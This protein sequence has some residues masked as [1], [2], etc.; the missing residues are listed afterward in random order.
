MHSRFKTYRDSYYLKDHI[1]S[2]KIIVGD[3]TYYAGYQHKE[4]FESRVW[5]LDEIDE[6][7]DVDKLIIGKFCS[8][9]SGCTFVM[10][11]NQ[12]HRHDWISTYP[13]DGFDDD[14][15][16]YETHVPKAF[17]KKGDTI[18]G[19][20]VWIGAEAMIM[21]GITIGNGAV[22]ASRAVV[23]K[24]VPSYAIVGGNPAK[25]IKMRFSDEEIVL[26][27]QIAWWNWDSE[28]IK[29]HLAIL[30]SGDVRA[31]AVK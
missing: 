5:Y 4:D 18:I 8:L 15:I 9:G 25:T 30:R 26:L 7:K 16:N 3:Y 14:F 29:K 10:C 1:K 12:G 23:T 2:S 27:E 20:D 17:Q 31:L 28:K 21:P 24:N 6:S 22:I 11:G 19:N 13:L